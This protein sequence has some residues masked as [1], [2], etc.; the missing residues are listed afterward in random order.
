MTTQSEQLDT[1]H[2]K[3]VLIAVGIVVAMLAFVFVPDWGQ[4]K[5]PAIPPAGVVPT[6]EQ[7]ASAWQ[8]L[9]VQA[10]KRLDYSDNLAGAAVAAGQINRRPVDIARAW[11]DGHDLHMAI[12]PLDVPA[13]L[14]QEADAKELARLVVTAT[15]VRAAAF[16]KGLDSMRADGA[17]ADLLAMQDRIERA[18]KLSEAARVLI[19]KYTCS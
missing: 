14:D 17:P 9:T 4:P 11:K 19:T 10:T 7:V 12:K 5:Q 1:N 8:D 6:A 16:E 18:K 15:S 13:A 3:A 2:G